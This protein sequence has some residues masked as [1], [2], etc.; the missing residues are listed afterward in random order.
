MK[1]TFK[2]CWKEFW[3]W[4]ETNWKTAWIKLRS[5]LLDLIVAL[6]SW[7]Y[8]IVGSFLWG[9]WKL[10]LLPVGKCTKDALIKWIKKI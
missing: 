8:T 6:C 5:A 2:S 3:A 1:E 4:V 7:L 10:F 9:L